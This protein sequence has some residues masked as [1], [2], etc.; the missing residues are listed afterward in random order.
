MLGAAAGFVFAILAVGA[1]RFLSPQ[2]GLTRFQEVSFDSH[3]WFF[4]CGITIVSSLLFG[5]APAW[6]RVGSNLGSSLKDEGSTA[7]TH[8]RQR[9][10]AQTGLVTIQVAFACLL[11]IAAGLLVRSFQIV[12]NVR[13]GFNSDHIVTAQLSLIGEQALT[14]LQPDIDYIRS[15]MSRSWIGPGVYR[16]GVS[17]AAAIRN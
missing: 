9:Q 8:S 3:T 14:R 7:T 17:D 12:Q 16:R 10:R 5:L 13:L 11:L 15:L 2:D 1:I 6:S 4:F